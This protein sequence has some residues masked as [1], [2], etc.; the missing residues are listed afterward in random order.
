MLCLCSY[1]LLNLSIQISQ[2]GDFFDQLN[3]HVDEDGSTNND[4]ALSSKATVHLSNDWV[5]TSSA[6]LLAKVP[7]T[8][9]EVSAVRHSYPPD[10]VDNHNTLSAFSSFNQNRFDQNRNRP[11]LIGRSPVLTSAAL[12]TPS[13]LKKSTS[14]K[15]QNTSVK[16]N[17]NLD[18]KTP[19]PKSDKDHNTKT[20]SANLLQ[21]ECHNQKLAYHANVDNNNNE[22][23]YLSLPFQMPISRTMLSNHEK[24]V[25][26]I[27]SPEAAQVKWLNN[28]VGEQNI[29]PD[30]I[31]SSLT[32]R[33]AKVADNQTPEKTKF[34]TNADRISHDKIGTSNQRKDFNTDVNFKNQQT[35]LESSA[36]HVVSQASSIF[37]GIDWSITNEEPYVAPQISNSE[38]HP[39]LSIQKANDA[40]LSKSTNVPDSL[41]QMTEMPSIQIQF[42]SKSA[43]LDST[44]TQMNPNASQYVPSH[45]RTVS[46]SK[47]TAR[48]N[49]Q[50]K[51]VSDESSQ[52][53]SQTNAINDGYRDHSD[54]VSAHPSYTQRMQY[55]NEQ[56]LLDGETQPRHHF[57]PYRQQFDDHYHVKNHPLSLSDPG[58]SIQYHVEQQRQQEIEY[59]NTRNRQLRRKR[60]DHLSR[61]RGDYALPKSRGSNKNKKGKSM[62]EKK[63]N[64]MP[65]TKKNSDAK[66]VFAKYR[67][68]AD[69]VSDPLLTPLKCT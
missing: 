62:K 40:F 12:A 22:S 46:R 10:Y 55:T 23:N 68:L 11:T 69:Q 5:L 21:Y 34:Q 24:E 20:Q 31:N 37:N 17:N 16:A 56:R 2:A 49:M 29:G 36:Q 8:N 48:V 33:I 18:N 9:K 64:N 26:T 59:H 14:I 39:S 30:I 61:S 6:D 52:I 50:S 4:I 15:V 3:K 63:A 38:V 45:L 57:Q 65:S 67:D 53:L 41:N 13:P 35:P 28:L 60:G 54:V 25:S 42:L 32:S 1:I 66:K 51:G 7:N 47:K 58:P 27:A 43:E 44:R 19:G